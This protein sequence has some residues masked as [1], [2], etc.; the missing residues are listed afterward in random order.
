MGSVAERNR[1]VSKFVVPMWTA[2]V[3]DVRQALHAAS[4]AIAGDSHGRWGELQ[5]IVEADSAEQAVARVRRA[6]GYN[7]AV[8]PAASP[9]PD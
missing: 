8:P 9:V 7:A 3:P 5:A 2:R 6:V 4:I 1:L